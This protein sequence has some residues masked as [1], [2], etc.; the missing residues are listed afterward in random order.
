MLIR[1]NDDVT[2]GLTTGHWTPPVT[3]TIEHLSKMITFLK[4]SI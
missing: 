1:V 4:I 3:S 2:G